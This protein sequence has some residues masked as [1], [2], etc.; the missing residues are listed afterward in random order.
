MRP[1]LSIPARGPTVY[2][3]A[4][5][6]SG[7]PLT[8]IGRFTARIG[9]A[10]ADRGAGVRFF[11]DDHELIPPRGLDW[12]PDQDL[13]RWA[14]RIWNDSRLV[15][16][17][18]VP[19]D[20]VGLWTATR[21]RERR[22][23][24]E[25]SIL[26]D[27]SPLIIPGAHDAHSR[28]IFQFFY[29]SSLLSSDAALAVSHSTRADA[30]WL[31][32]FPQDR[33]AVAH[34]GP[35]HCM[36]RHLH[37]RSVAR[38][39]KSAWWSPRSIP[40]TIPGS[41]STGSAPRS[42]C[43]TAPSS[44]GR[45]VSMIRRRIA[46]PGYSGAPTDEAGDVHM[47]GTVSDRRLCELYRTAGWSIYP[48]IYDGFAYPVL[49]ALR[50]G[51]PVLTGCHSSL[52]E[53]AHPGVH[54]FDPDD[55]ASLDRAWVDSQAAGPDRIAGTPLDAT[56]QLGLRRGRHPRPRARRPPRRRP[57]R[58]FSRS[59]GV[60]FLKG[61]RGPSPL[62]EA[63]GIPDHQAARSSSQPEAPSATSPSRSMARRN[64]SVTRL[65]LP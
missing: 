28:A 57:A 41:S 52:R 20:A 33:I 42:R 32:D 11:A 12:S 31:T 5:Q 40:G 4:T 36:R 2:L 50:H 23:S 49:D 26:H 62:G 53:L 3:D 58:P 24:V 37:G 61:R 25:L 43:R 46:S 7:R 14:A 60:G 35:S 54:F 48:S 10:L 63:P 18:A 8:G 47:L 29:A 16:L 44:G 9:M 56:L 59:R 15:P 51:A 38:R 27:L 13:N 1:H 64:A 65:T 45:A 22:F 21:P 34:P 55:A 39:R 30:G 19:E 6:L 17:A